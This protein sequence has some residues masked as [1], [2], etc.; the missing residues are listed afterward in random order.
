MLISPGTATENLRGTN[1]Q[2][3]HSGEH[4]QPWGIQAFTVQ[5]CRLWLFIDNLNIKTVA[6]LRS[7]CRM[8]ERLR[9]ETIYTHECRPI[10]SD[11]PN[12]GRKTCCINLCSLCLFF[13]LP[14]LSYL[15]ESLFRHFG[16]NLCGEA[17]LSGKI[18]WRSIMRRRETNT[19]SYNGS[20]LIKKLFLLFRSFS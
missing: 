18:N 10:Q 9:Q 4:T 3:R 6:L 13:S 5:N 7:S 17:G 14:H 12:P 1:K 8:K 20:Y 2:K 16:A 15:A 11:T 19:F